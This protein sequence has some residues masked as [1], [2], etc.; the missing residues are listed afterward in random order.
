MAAGRAAWSATRA[1]VTAWLTEP[2]HAAAVRRTCLDLD[3][4]AAGACR[5]PAW[6]DLI[7]RGCAGPVGYGRGMRRVGGW[8]HGSHVASEEVRDPDHRPRG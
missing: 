8:R 4:S 2:A 1:A 6:L 5:E 7:G 3:A